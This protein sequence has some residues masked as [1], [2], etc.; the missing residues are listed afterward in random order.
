M[1][2]HFSEKYL[3][4]RFLSIFLGSMLC[5]IMLWLMDPSNSLLLSSFS[6]GVG[7]IVALGTL[8]KSYVY[9]AMLHIGRKTLFDFIDLGDI[10]DKVM[11][12]ENSTGAGL[13][14]VGVGL[15]AIAIA[16]VIAAATISTL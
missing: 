4:F 1:F 3:R 10:Y 8:T 13:Y 16:I 11:K 9:I 15:F 7:L 12:S 2:E 6:A 14:M 5:F